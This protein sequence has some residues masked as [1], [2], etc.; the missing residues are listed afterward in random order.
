MQ[1]INFF[2]ID[3]ET[4][5]L[6]KKIHEVNE[7]SI[8]R[9]SN[10]V[11]LTVFI[12]CEHPESASYDALVK[13]NKTIEDLSIG[14][15]KEEAIAKVDKF[16]NEDGLTPAHRCFIAHNAKFDRKFLHS[17]YEQVNKQCPVNLWLC[18]LELMRKY[19]KDIGLKS[20]INLEASCDIVGIKKF[21][22]G[23]ASKIDSRNAYLLW[24][25]LV[26]IKKID[27]LPFIKTIMHGEEL[28][29]YE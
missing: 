3:L 1:G 27:Y 13:T 17:L 24:K 5:G 2:S 8:I 9:C 20:K 10:R 15:S 22:G 11:Q 18:T 7:I 12:K 4:T 28:N 29:N 19:T 6:N 25:D 16:L 23:H 21:S 14:I 26:E